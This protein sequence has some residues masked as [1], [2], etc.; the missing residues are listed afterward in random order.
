MREENQT[1]YGGFLCLWRTNGATD[2]IEING[3]TCYDSDANAVAL[4]NDSQG[5]IVLNYNKFSNYVNKFAYPNY[6]YGTGNVF[7]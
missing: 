5:K 3:N 1:G 6:I 4:P 2:K 7:N